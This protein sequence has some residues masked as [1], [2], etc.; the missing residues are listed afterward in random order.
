LLEQTTLTIEKECK[1]AHLL[2]T[3]STGKAAMA[4][5]GDTPWHGLGQQLTADSSIETWAEESGLDFQL[6][7]TDVQFTPPASVWNGYKPA[8]S[9]YTGKKVMYRTDSNL[10]LGLVSNQ[11]KIV[12]PIEV[13]E[14]FRDMVGT[15][16]N[17]E[18]AGVL[19]N[20]AHYWALAKMD[21]EFA[22][23]GDKVDQYLL[24]ASSC[25]G[26]LAT[27]AR[28]TS[29]RVVCNNTLQLAQGSGQAIQVRH[30]SVFDPVSVKTKLA[31]F[32]ESFKAFEHTA[33]FLAGIKVSSTQAQAVFTKLLGGDD[34]KPSRAATRALALFEGA[35][36][37]SELESAKGTAW[38][39]LNAVTQL[40]DWETARTG[41][42]RL[43]NAW[44]G[45][46][47]NIKSKAMEE[48][49]A[50]G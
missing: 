3:T 15:I 34:K 38:G 19:R 27:Q 37:G 48:L 30:N 4:Y 18:T 33:K 43:A 39:A 47:V 9:V 11:Y 40:M 16:A 44:F 17:L 22:I 36:I 8:A 29:V 10:P 1:M 6:A 23:A 35:G 46:G 24:L 50:L 25:D 21:G 42:A 28:L 13:L 12:Q 20:G 45:G 26:S 14:F 32:N 2:A 41:D 49:L 5:V 31:D 7:T